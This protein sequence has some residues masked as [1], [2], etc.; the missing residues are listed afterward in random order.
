MMS[1]A[2][3]RK[4]VKENIKGNFWKI[5]GFNFLV[6][7]LTSMISNVLTFEN[8]FINLV[9]AVI[10]AGVTTPITVGF[11]RILI[12]ILE[13]KDAKIDTL[14]EYFKDFLNLFILGFI[15]NLAISI[16][17]MFFVIPGVILQIIYTGILYLYL[18]NP[19]MKLQDLARDGFQKMGANIWRAF[20]LT[21][22]YTW[23]IIIMVFVFCIMLF[24]IFFSNLAA[25]T[26]GMDFST[27]LVSNT[28]SLIF[29]IVLVI[30]LLIVSLYIG[31]RLSLAQAVF[32]SQ[33]M[34]NSKN[35]VNK[36][37]KAEFC[38]NC[39]SKV[40]GNFCTNCGNKL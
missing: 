31:P 4:F 38:P 27:L 8:E 2:E 16:G 18:L 37:M 15:G 36:P 21:L 3:I 29:S 25:Y 19:K 30:I 6:S 12:D 1:N 32:Y 17:S 10:A 34:G 33:I 13:K 20:T 40:S 14:F 26:S 11:Y 7:L 9:F 35:A 28:Y 39:G 22:S 5:L 23:P 24:S